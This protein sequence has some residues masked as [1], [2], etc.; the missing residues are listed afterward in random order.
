MI[1]VSCVGALDCA[2]VPSEGLLALAG[3]SDAH[4]RRCSPWEAPSSCGPPTRQVM[5]SGER[6][7]PSAGSGNG[8]GSRHFPSLE[9][10]FD[11]H[12]FRL[13]FSVVVVGRA[14]HRGQ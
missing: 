9:R 2:E 6:L 4:G 7:D 12:G 5:S 13:C 3:R 11:D 8:D 14:Q 10:R 1:V